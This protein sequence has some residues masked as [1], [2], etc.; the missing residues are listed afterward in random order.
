[1]ADWTTISSLATAGGTLVLATATYSSTRSANRAARIAERAMLANLRPVLLSSRPGDPPEKVM[2]ADQHHARVAGGRA[3]VDVVDDTIYLAANIHNAGNGI[4]VIHGW[5]LHPGWDPAV[6]PAEAETF[7]MQGRDLYI[8]SGENGFWQG[9]VREAD[10]PDR[11]AI[12]AAIVARDRM[13]LEIL[14]GDHEG[15]QRTITRFGL[16]PVEDDA[17]MC[18]TSRHWNLDRANPR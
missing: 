7:R 1:M 13:T 10:D 6:P 8:P 16:I 17:W 9:A 5:H 11:A 14:Y 18:T 12:S 4:A 2:W 3:V 15:G